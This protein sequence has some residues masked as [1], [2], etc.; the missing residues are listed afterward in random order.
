MEGFTGCMDMG[1]FQ[2]AGAAIRLVKRNPAPRGY[3]GCDKQK[4]GGKY[5]DHELLICNLNG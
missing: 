4:D 2:L 1:L 5:V 3:V